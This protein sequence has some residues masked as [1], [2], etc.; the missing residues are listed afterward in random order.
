M[1]DNLWD[2]LIKA[3]NRNENKHGVSR[4]GLCITSRGNKIEREYDLACKVCLEVV[5]INDKLTGKS[6]S[7]KKSLA[8]DYITRDLKGELKLT[9]RISPWGSPESIVF[10]QSWFTDEG[11]REIDKR[12]RK[13]SIERLEQQADTYLLRAGKLLERIENLKKEDDEG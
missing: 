8:A 7:K 2:D 4:I 6:H 11:R 5:K 3:L 12:V 13:A 10:D 9:Y 1:R